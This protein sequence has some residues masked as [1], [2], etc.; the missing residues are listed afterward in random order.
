MIINGIDC[1]DEFELSREEWVVLLKIIRERQQADI[2]AEARR[3][4][5]ERTKPERDAADARY[6]GVSL[7]EFLGVP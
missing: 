5:R 2:D 7:D 4:E 1:G 3:A 6:L